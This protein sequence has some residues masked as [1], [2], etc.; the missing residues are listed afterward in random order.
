[1]KSQ[2]KNTISRRKFI[3]TTAV[4]AA[5]FSIVPRHVLGGPGY[6]PPSDK[7]TIANIG[8]GTQGLREMTQ[9]LQHPEVQV[10]AV[11]DPNK[12]TT[13][14]LDWTPTDIRDKIRET[15]EDPTWGAHC[16]GV[17][18]G[19]DI[20]KELVDK[21]YAKNNPSG[22]Y[23]GCRSYED[24]REL[25]EK[26]HDLDAIKIMTPDH[27][28]AYLAIAAMKKGKHVISHKPI[29][30]RMREGKLAIETAKETGV[31]T[32]LLAWSDRPEYDFVL[33]WIQD[34][35]IGTLKEIHNWS[36]RPVWEQWPKRP[37]DT[38]A[39]PNGFNWDLWLG[40]VP[41]L[42]YHPHYTHNVFRGWYDFGGGSIAD[43]GHYSL[44]P[45]FR[46]F[47]INTA[48]VSAKAYGTTHRYV[49]GNTYLWL[50]NDVSFPMSCLIQL[51]FPEQEKLPA[52]DLFWYDGGMKPFITKE[53][54][55]DD[56]DMPS[57]GMMFVGDKG[58]ILAGFR[59]EN[60]QIIP[61]KRMDDYDGDKEIPERDPE[62]N[63][64]DKRT[65][66]WVAAI[67]NDKES[68]G[69]FLYAGPVTET[70]NLAAVALRAKKKIT[71][72]SEAMEITNYED[73]NKYLTR[74][75]REGW[76]L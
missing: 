14:Y 16:T 17:P 51:S 24:Y 68:A 65:D 32:H 33:K 34:G 3:Q 42:P 25:L 60:P 64:R 46:A 58:R 30:N 56:R 61:E 39:I 41:H 71:Y 75:Y 6:I 38:P 12:F 53:F 22:T 67:K 55:E 57:E 59:G 20:G 37:T 76:E 70:I 27:H 44:F 66:T 62:E 43:M 19:R 1:M 28:H 35:A 7:I 49:D 74:E 72:D 29:A 73:A 18:G 63:K 13:N 4:A 52:F 5:T 36:Y 23:E 8:C 11:C 10:V 50:E 48:P 21:Y 15:I 26:E 54:D 40:P 2:E 9:L 31:K 69:S 47:G 45:L